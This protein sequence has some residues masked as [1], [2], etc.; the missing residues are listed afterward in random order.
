MTKRRDKI[1]A[2][3][4]SE[5]LG[6][7]WG[8]P[9]EFGDD[10]WAFEGPNRRIFVTYDPESEP[11]QEWV[12]ASIAHQAPYRMPSYGE[13]KEMHA[14][15]FGDG[16]AYQCFVPPSAHI[17]ITSNVLHL[18]GRLDGANVLPDFG[19]LGTI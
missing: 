13:L 18:W 4:I 2:K 16:F 11:G 12:H 3:A 9:T 1:D 7:N 6:P 15:V 10:G 8:Q 17:N 5:R 19:R 14:A